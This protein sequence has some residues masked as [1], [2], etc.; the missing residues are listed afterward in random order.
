MTDTPK[1]VEQEAYAAGLK[2]GAIAK[3]VRGAV[4]ELVKGIQEASK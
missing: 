3:R 2:L 4:E 1:P